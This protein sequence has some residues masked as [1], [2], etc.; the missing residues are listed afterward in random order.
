MSS[1]VFDFV[2]RKTCKPMEIKLLTEACKQS[3]NTVSSFIMPECRKLNPFLCFS[4]TCVQ[5]SRLPRIACIVVAFAF[6]V[7]DW[8]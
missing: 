4:A 5:S 7:G 1:S 8:G 6:V 2:C 3:G